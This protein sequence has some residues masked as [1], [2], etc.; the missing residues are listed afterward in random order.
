MTMFMYF[1]YSI[2][3]SIAFLALLPYFIYQAFFHKKY[4]SNFRERLG[5]LPESL[6][7][8]ARPTIW[9]HAVS[10]GETL[11]AHS[12]VNALRERFP[13]HRLIFSTTT[14][15]GQAVARSR[16]TEADGFCYYPF[17]WKFSV[18]NALKVIQ[19]RIV[20]LMES[21]LW[22]NFLRECKRQD[23]PV[24]VANG[25][26]SDRSFQRAQKVQFWFRRLTANVTCFLMQ[27]EADAAR[28]KALGASQVFVSGNIKYD[29]GSDKQSAIIDANA[30]SINEALALDQSPLII[31]GSTSD[32]EEELLLSALAEV[33]KT[34]GLDDVRLLLAPRHPERFETVAKLLDSSRFKYARR[35]AFVQQVETAGIGNY[36]ALPS[37]KSPVQS[38]T[39]VLLDSIGELASLYRFASIVFVGGSLVPK[40]G[41]NVLE[42]AREAKPII[43]GPYM[44]NFREIAA[45]FQ[46][47]DALIQVQ[48]T[49]DKELTA[50]LSASLIELLRD[51]ER[52]KSLGA[53]ARA[54]V[55][56]NRGATNKTVEVIASII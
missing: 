6:Q 47:N 5:I 16:I 36:G 33:H 21:E 44:E 4:L 50:A 11:A 23:I 37:V 7:A 51:A 19:P 18:R 24:L 55:E 32:G 20:V 25:R 48:G 56:A 49:T 17:D 22:P 3:L 42:P 9:I 12:L 34:E 15:T 52:V 46:R 1:L 2:F 29:I 39:V 26:V 38:A 53:N 45:E 10:V 13:D 8:D 27:S 35:S 40:G 28:I 54:T 43:V 41:H 30:H 14:A 31:A